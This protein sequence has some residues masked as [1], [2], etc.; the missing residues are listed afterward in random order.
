[1]KLN[2]ATFRVQQMMRLKIIHFK[3]RRVRVG[4]VRVG[5]VRVGRVSG[6]AREGGACDGGA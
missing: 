2:F 5:C 1:M 4:C 6:G 3:N